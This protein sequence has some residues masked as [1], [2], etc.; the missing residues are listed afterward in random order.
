MLKRHSTNEN[1]TATT[2]YG[3]LPKINNR[4]YDN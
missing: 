4:I 3:H 1:T 2:D